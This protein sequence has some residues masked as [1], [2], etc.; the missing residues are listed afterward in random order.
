MRA[1][2]Y[3]PQ[4]KGAAPT[5]TMKKVPLFREV[6]D[7]KRG[8]RMSLI[9]NFLTVQNYQGCISPHSPRPPY[10]IPAHVVNTFNN[11]TCLRSGF[12][13]AVEFTFAKW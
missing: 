11:G 3:R 10:Q 2:K 8:K 1:W 9:G 12:N 13:R 6:V 4:K 5:K 7:N